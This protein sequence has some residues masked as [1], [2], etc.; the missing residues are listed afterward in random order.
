M[1]YSSIVQVKD[2]SQV[3]IFFSGVFRS[4]DIHES[5]VNEGKNVFFP[6]LY[7]PITATWQ[8]LFGVLI[9]KIRR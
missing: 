4:K 9:Y 8:S 7:E 1:L 2:Q 5:L 6:I 3:S